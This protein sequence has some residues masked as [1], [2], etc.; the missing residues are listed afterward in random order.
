MLSKSRWWAKTPM[1]PLKMCDNNDNHICGKD[2]TPATYTYYCEKN[3]TANAGECS[4]A[5]LC[6]G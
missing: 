2:Q 1:T 4:S 3:S 5:G 6:Q